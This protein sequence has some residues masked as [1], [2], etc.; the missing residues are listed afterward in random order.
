MREADARQRWKSRIGW[1]LLFWPPGLMSLLLFSVTA[2]KFLVDLYELIFGWL[3]VVALISIFVGRMLLLF[4]DH[5]ARRHSAFHQGLL[6]LSVTRDSR[7]GALILRSERSPLTTDYVI[8]RNKETERR[9]VIQHWYVEDL[10]NAFFDLGACW[11]IVI[12]A[13]EQGANRP[14]LQRFL[15]LS[16]PHHTW[17]ERLDELARDVRCIVIIP[18]MTPGIAYELEVIAT[19]HPRKTIVFMPPE[20]S[21]DDGL[22]AARWTRVQAHW[23][24][25]ANLRLPDYRKEGLLYLPNDDFSIRV[26]VDMQGSISRLAKAISA[27]LD[28]IAPGAVPAGAIVQE[29][30]LEHPESSEANMVASTQEDAYYF[31]DP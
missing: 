11:P 10:A 20:P 26:A 15:R 1:L 5:D 12:H 23:Q 14:H 6:W 30:D 31:R 24:A 16:L 28:E 18:E 22:C 3:A 13:S 29:T 9:V 25:S 27:L 19:R 4:A 7:P 17:R 21:S 2:R 8:V